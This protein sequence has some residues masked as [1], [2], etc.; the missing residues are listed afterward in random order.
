MTVIGCS[1]TSDSASIQ[2]DRQDFE[3]V[4]GEVGP[5]SLDAPEKKPL[6]GIG[7]HKLQRF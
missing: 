3:M 6:I 4:E 5:L 7:S 2:P 1:L